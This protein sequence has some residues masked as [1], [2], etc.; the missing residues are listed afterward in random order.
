MLFTLGFFPAAATTA[1][2]YV[3]AASTHAGAEQHAP[4]L[5]LCWHVSGKRSD[6]EDA[7][8]CSPLNRTCDVQFLFPGAKIN[9][10]FEAHTDCHSP[11]PPTEFGVCSDVMC[12][13]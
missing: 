3:H 2:V 5:T 13:F 7:R 11:A 6:V 12:L 9:K 8:D 10:S 1:A 4:R